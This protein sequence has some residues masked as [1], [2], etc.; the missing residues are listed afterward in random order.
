LG[1]NELRLGVETLSACWFFFSSKSEIDEMK[2]VIV[3]VGS[4]GK[5]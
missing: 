5:W 1:A 4:K 3:D 2:K